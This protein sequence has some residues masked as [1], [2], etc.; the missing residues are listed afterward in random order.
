MEPTILS[1]RVLEMEESAT[2]AMGKK[3]GELRAQ[4][5]DVVDLSAGEP[6]FDTPQHIKD[7]ASEALKAGRTKYTPVS[8]IPELRKAVAAKL[9]RDQGVTYDPAEVLIS[10]GA[11]HVIYNLLQAL[12]DGDDEVLIPTP[13]WTSYPEMVKCAGGRPIP[14]VTEEADGFRLRPAALEQAIN[15]KTKA[16]LYSSPSNPTGCV[17]PES[18]LRAV[19]SILEETDVLVLSDE[20]YEKF[21][22]GNARH[23][24]FAQL[25]PDARERTVIINSVSKTYAMTGWRIGYAAGPREIIAAAG[26]IQSQATSNPNSIAQYA[27]VAA[28]TGDQSPVPVMAAEYAKRRDYVLS[29]LREMPHLPCVAPEGAFYVFPNISAHLGKSHSG[30]AVS[31]SAAMAALLLERARVALV[32]GSGFGSDAHLRISYATNLDRLTEGLNR[33]DRFLRE[34]L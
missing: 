5:I 2:L 14:L 6:D 26:K 24:S 8:G 22:Y 27:A 32:P 23:V 10:C 18:D 12:L 31:S 4:G 1:R 7:A 29:R 21:L 11:K 34:L 3:A 15:S 25:G 17:Y 20:V 33:I 9:L 19:L 30:A 28:L 13:Y 16:I